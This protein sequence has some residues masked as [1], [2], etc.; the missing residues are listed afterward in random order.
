M[1]DFTKSIVRFRAL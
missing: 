1:F